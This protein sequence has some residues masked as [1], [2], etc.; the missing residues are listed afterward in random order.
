MPGRCLE[1]GK[2]FTFKFYSNRVDKNDLDIVYQGHF[3]SIGLD[4]KWF[5]FR[6]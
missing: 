3:L 4:C 1:T 5:I 2:R 6:R